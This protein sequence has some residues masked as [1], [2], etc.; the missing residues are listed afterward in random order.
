MQCALSSE[1]E[2]PALSGQ[3][4]RMHIESQIVQLFLNTTRKVSSLERQDA[5]DSLT[6]VLQQIKSALHTH[7]DDADT[8]IDYLNT[9]YRMVGHTRDI[10]VGKGERMAS[11]AMLM[12]FHKVYP[13]L[14]EY[15]LYSFVF[16]S[17]EGDR[18][19]GSWRDIGPLCEY[20][21]THS[22][23]REDHSLI[24]LFIEF[25][26][27]QLSCDTN[28]WKYA[29]IS[30]KAKA[31]QISNVAKWIP[32]ENKK[33]AWIFDRLYMDWA[34]RQYPYILASVGSDDSRR[35]AHTKCK[36]LYRKTLAKLNRCLDTPEIKMCAQQWHNIEPQT[37]QMN[38]YL[39]HSS[40]F[41]ETDSNPISIDSPDTQSKKQICALN[42]KLFVP[43]IA[44]NPTSAVFLPIGYM[45]RR[46]TTLIEA[47]SILDD[48]HH[49]LPEITYLNEQWHKMSHHIGSWNGPC[50]LPIVDVSLT[51]WENEENCIYSAIGLA[52][53]IAMR[54]GLQNRFVAMDK[55]PKWIA[56]DETADFAT[57]VSSVMVDIRTM[58]KTLA[59]IQN[60]F[61]WIADAITGSNSS[62]RFM[63]NTTIIM[64]SD[65]RKDILKE[66]I[67]EKYIRSPIVYW[68][69][70]SYVNGDMINSLDPTNRYVSGQTISVLKQVLSM[71]TN[72]RTE[73]Q[74]ECVR[75][76]LGASRYNRL[77]DYLAKMQ[78]LYA[79][80][81]AHAQ[82]KF[83]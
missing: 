21:K 46:I 28:I 69:M 48:R 61:E 73:S 10:H 42:Y 47:G 65:C 31:T 33:Y 45:V 13:V 54:S 5:D 51:M 6:A 32:R 22:K 52:I 70:G 41:T 2:F 76:Q 8:Y 58:Q 78:A 44:G 38:T 20:L 35:N 14:A 19:Y 16:P 7:S 29:E 24:T 9:L 17:T 36:Q 62:A 57:I 11:Y 27:R 55:Y 15:A 74:Y 59:N 25:I 60:T 67:R 39:K 72:N 63:E 30:R 23:K 40:L 18:Q 83:T 49:Y 37:V 1:E 80:A 64:F 4:P 75:T 12:A 56:W 71:I 3:S 43:G 77:S 68:N 53:L 79:F 81:P 26:N 50:I 34:E 82:L 66:N